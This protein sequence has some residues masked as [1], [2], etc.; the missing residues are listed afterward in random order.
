VFQGLRRPS[1]QFRETSTLNMGR[2]VPYP[3]NA[4]QRGE[5]R[6]TSQVGDLIRRGRGQGRAHPLH[7]RG[8][9]GWKK[10]PFQGAQRVGATTTGRKKGVSAH[11]SRWIWKE[12]R[13]QASGKLDPN[14]ARR[15]FFCTAKEKEVGSGSAKCAGL[16]VKGRRRK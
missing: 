11:W 16:G 8:S 1:R 10:S 14:A 7:R 12:I 3:S 4:R 6:K 15:Q 9:S 2:E 5:G 13:A